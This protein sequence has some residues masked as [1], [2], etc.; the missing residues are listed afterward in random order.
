MLN[1]LLAGISRGIDPADPSDFARYLGAAMFYF[2]PHELPLTP[3]PSQLPLWVRVPYLKWSL[4]VPQCFRESSEADLHAR[5]L[6]GWL[7]TLTT[8][9]GDGRGWEDM[10]E[11]QRPRLRRLVAPHLGPVPI[12]PPADWK[13]AS[14]AAD[15][16]DTSNGR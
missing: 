15:L 11:Y 6:E 3:V 9:L 1:E 8:E 12:I 2:L 5:W 10:P 16:V 4:A 7:K 13:N 14:S